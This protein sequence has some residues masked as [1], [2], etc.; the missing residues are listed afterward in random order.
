MFEFTGIKIFTDMNTI[1][2]W[3][4]TDVMQSNL[5]KTNVTN[6]PVV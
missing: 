5:K 4:E 6:N 1:L 3:Y 2:Q